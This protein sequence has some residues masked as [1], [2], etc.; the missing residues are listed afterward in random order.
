MAVLLLST[1]CAAAGCSDR[2]GGDAEGAGHTHA[3]GGASVSMLVGDGTRDVEVGY[4]LADVH[5]PEQAGEFG[6]VTFRIERFDGSTVRDYIVEQTKKLHLYVVRTDLAVFRH[7][8]PTMSADG[9]WSAPVTLP[10]PGEYR[11]LAEFVAR[12]EGGNGDF[13]M[14]GSTSRVPGPWRPEPVPDSREGDD[15]TVEVAARGTVAVGTDG[16]LTLEVRDASQRPVE[17]GSYLGTSAHL[18]GFQVETG[19]AVH[20]HPLGA[21]QVD[22]D[23]TRLRFHTEFEEPGDYRLFVQVRVDGYVH[24]VPVTVDVRPRGSGS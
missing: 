2:A 10:E 19:A 17:L 13:V 24:T 6:R 14:L 5:I 1:L 15:G 22:Q 20:M 23:A 12:D 4:R 7:L 9:T 8:H 3:A 18:T 21:P 16:R 11:V